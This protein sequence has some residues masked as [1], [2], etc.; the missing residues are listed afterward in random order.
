ML[1]LVGVGGRGHGRPC[2]RAGTE[3]LA[4]D[5]LPEMLGSV[6]FDGAPAGRHFCMR[7]FSLSVM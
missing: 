7:L 2:T 4:N 3:R 5:E 6:V 1:P